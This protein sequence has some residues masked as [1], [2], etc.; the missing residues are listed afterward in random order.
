MWVYDTKGLLVNPVAISSRFIYVVTN[1]KEH[2]SL[3]INILAF[4]KGTYPG[5]EVVVYG[6]E[7][8]PFITSLVDYFSATARNRWTSGYQ[9]FRLPDT[10]PWTFGYQFNQAQQAIIDLAR[11]AREQQTYNILAKSF[12]Y[13]SS[14]FSATALLSSFTLT[15]FSFVVL[16][17]F[18]L[19]GWS[20]FLIIL[21]AF[22][23][24]KVIFLATMSN[25]A[26]EME[27]SF[28]G[29]CIRSVGLMLKNYQLVLAGIITTTLGVL[30]SLALF[31]YLSPAPTVSMFYAAI[32]LTWITLLFAGGFFR[33]FGLAFLQKEQLNLA[34]L[35]GVIKYALATLFRM[36][37]IA[38][39]HLA[40]GLVICLLLGLS[41]SYNFYLFTTL[42]ILGLT[43]AAVLPIFADSYIVYERMAPLKALARSSYLA[44]LNIKAVMVYVTFMAIVLG[45]CSLVVNRLISSTAG[46]VVSILLVVLVSSY[47]TNIH[48]MLFLALNKRSKL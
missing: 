14:G 12:N 35:S 3:N 37:T 15:P 20:F 42:A 38:F 21:S 32:L 45:F 24:T 43:L 9:T 10:I 29:T 31:N 36:F 7:E 17:T 2:K 18:L 11:S 6:H 25:E 28:V 1:I 34:D 4:Q 22:G 44:I 39:I 13:F 47:L 40:S 48:S 27:F 30:V 41:E 33:T 16:L 46:A 26:N 5:T 8:S 19:L 23:I